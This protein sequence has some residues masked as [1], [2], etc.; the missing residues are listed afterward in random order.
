MHKQ[1]QPLLGPKVAAA[2]Y[3]WGVLAVLVKGFIYDI[4][5]Y[6]VFLPWLMF[7]T[8]QAFLITILLLAYLWL[9]T[10]GKKTQPPAE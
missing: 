3:V 8:L 5:W 1:V 10:F 4:S 9:V 7:G 2:V 6:V